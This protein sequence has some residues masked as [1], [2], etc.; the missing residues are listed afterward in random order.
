MIPTHLSRALR[1]L[2]ALPILF[3]FVYTTCPQGPGFSVSMQVGGL[4]LAASTCH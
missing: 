2:A 3:A 1:A 4:H